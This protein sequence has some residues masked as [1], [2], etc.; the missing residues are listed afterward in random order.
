VT[1]TTGQLSFESGGCLVRES[2]ISASPVLLD[3]QC[4]Y[5]TTP[6]DG[7]N[8][9]AIPVRLALKNLGEWPVAE[10][11]IALAKAD[12]LYREGAKFARMLRNVG[13]APTIMEV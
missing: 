8:W 5:L 7:K 10:A 4:L 11:C 9:Q 13:K 3:F 6:E 1:G 2:R 12:L